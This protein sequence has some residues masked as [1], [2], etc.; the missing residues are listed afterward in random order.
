MWVP[1]ENRADLHHGAFLRVAG[2]DI[3]KG[4]PAETRSDHSRG[5]G[6]P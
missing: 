2:H 5:D 4:I 1:D 6:V 3:V